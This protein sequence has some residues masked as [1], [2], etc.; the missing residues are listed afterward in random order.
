MKLNLW[1]IA[2]RLYDL[3]PEIHV[4][5]DA[6]INL[7]S[8]RRVYADRCAY[9]YQ[10]GPDVICD[11]GTDG[12]YLRFKEARCNQIFEMIQ[13]A[14]DFYDDWFEEMLDC[15]ET[16]DYE[17]AIDKSWPIFHNPILLLD[18]G[19]CLLSHSKQ[20]GPDEVNYDWQHLCTN[21]FSAVSVIHYLMQYNH[22]I[23]G[24]YSDS[25]AKVYTFPENPYVSTEISALITSGEHDLG[26]LNIIEK[27]R[28]LNPGD[29]YMA[30]YL[31][32][33]LSQILINVANN[34]LQSRVLYP[35][36]G[37][38]LLGQ[39]ITPSEI[40]YWKSYFRWKPED[41]IQVIVLTPKDEAPDIRQMLQICSLIQNRI[42]DCLATEA[43]NKIAFIYRCSDNPV[44]IA[45]RLN[46]II[47]Q[48]SLSVGISNPFHGLDHI[49][50]FYEQA[51]FAERFGKKHHPDK[52]CHYFIQYA[53]DYL[54]LSKDIKHAVYAV[55]PDIQS[56][57]DPTLP[58]GGQSI[59]TL[60]KYLY[61]DR[62]MMQAASALNLAKSTFVYRLNKVLKQLSADLEDGY[63]RDYLKIS[64]RVMNL[65]YQ[66][67]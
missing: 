66:Y 67:E 55:H 38:M 37:K 49:H 22:E 59:E 52:A 45:D 48:F 56:I 51:V 6:P 27:D 36:L 34:P 54:L 57:W 41:L 5:D 10:K 21:G 35:T 65:Y 11:A 26:R 2:N 15:I 3:E 23:R 60:Q 50:E 39:M 7:H 63:T 64:I 1:A 19:N 33:F 17:R 4:P 30:N 13:F 8:A 42:P 18:S 44:S 16:A 40:V 58:S 14:F 46:K 31:L 20:Y 32:K 12:G 24:F 29:L 61:F 62:S 25:K 47:E 43:E 9:V 53:I 28:Q